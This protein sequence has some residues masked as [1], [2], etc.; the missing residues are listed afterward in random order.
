[1]FPECG[2]TNHVNVNTEVELFQ[3]STLSETNYRE[4]LVWQAELQIDS[5]IFTTD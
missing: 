4:Q 1:M 3:L 2:G 5:I